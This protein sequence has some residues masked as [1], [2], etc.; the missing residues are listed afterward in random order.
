MPVRRTFRIRVVDDES[1]EIFGLGF[2]SP[3]V[4]ECMVATR[5]RWF[6]R[7]LPKDCFSRLWEQ[8]TRVN[9][10]RSLV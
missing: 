3:A 8:I 4:P 9:W 1:V 2:G 10:M 5:S 7:Y 6:M